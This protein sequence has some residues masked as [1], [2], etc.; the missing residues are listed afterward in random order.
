MRRAVRLVLAAVVVAVFALPMATSDAQEAPADPADAVLAIVSP[1]AS[2]VCGLTGTSTLLVPVVS[3]LITP[4]LPPGSPSV[5]DL[6]LNAL[7]PVFVVCGELPA[8]P[9]TRCLIDDQI[10]GLVPIEVSSITGPLPALLGNLLDALGA[11]LAALGLPPQTALEEALQ[12]SVR[13]GPGVIDAPGGDAPV[14]A[15]PAGGIDDPGFASPSFSPVGA[16]PLPSLTPSS[17]PAPRATSGP[18]Q[19]VATVD[20]LVPGG[21]KALQVIATGLLGLT[22]LSGWAGSWVES[23]RGAGGAS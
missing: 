17:A 18:E 2:P 9:G 15:P 16:A 12:C 23:R 4:S 19:L 3:G 10:A 22:L 7:G 14:E 8:A 20:R 11:A 5:G 6:L 21:V 13:E 1:I